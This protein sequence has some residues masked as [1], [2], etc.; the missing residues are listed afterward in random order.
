MLAFNGHNVI[1]D[2]EVVNANQNVNKATTN[3]TISNENMNKL[4]KI[5]RYRTGTCPSDNSTL[6]ANNSGFCPANS[7]V[8]ACYSATP[9]N[10]TLTF[11]CP[12]QT[13]TIVKDPFGRFFF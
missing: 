1:K 11:K 4:F 13:G 2:D 3:R 8:L 7:D 6:Q 9:A 10:T 5:F 12:Y